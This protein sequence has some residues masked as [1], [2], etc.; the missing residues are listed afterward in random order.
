MSKDNV[1]IHKIKHKTTFEF[2]DNLNS[3]FPIEHKC[4]NLSKQETK[5]K[6]H[7]INGRI[8]MS[9]KSK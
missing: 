8:K 3:L 2:R 6:F 4:L 9:F 5:T 1:C 7:L